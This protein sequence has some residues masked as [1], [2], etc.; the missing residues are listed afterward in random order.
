VTVSADA[1]GRGA[2]RVSR[3]GG[4]SDAAP[5]AGWDVQAVD[6]TAAAATAIDAAARR[7]VRVISASRTLLT[8]GCWLLIYGGLRI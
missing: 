5:G 4:V 8:A 3:N 6:A 7:M 2:I 1:A